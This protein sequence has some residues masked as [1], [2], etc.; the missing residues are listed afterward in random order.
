MTRSVE[1]ELMIG[2]VKRPPKSI[3]AGLRSISTAAGP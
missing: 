1:E 3:V 2:S